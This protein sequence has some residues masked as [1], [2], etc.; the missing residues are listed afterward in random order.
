MTAVMSYCAL[1]LLLVLGKGIRTLIPLLQKLYLP[2][3]I[4]GGILGLVCL[5]AGGG[6]LPTEWS[7]GWA[8]IPGFLINIVF[9][10]LF[11][12]RS[13]PKIGGIRRSVASQLCFGQIMAWGMYVVGLGITALIL[14]PCFHVPPVFG[15]LLEIG[16]EGGHGTVGGL[17][18]TFEELGWDAG[19]ALGYTT[20][21][22]GMVI[23]I[24]VGM[25]LINFAVRRKQVKNIRSFEELT[26]AEQKGFYPVNAQPP[27]GKQ[28]VLCDSIDSLAWHVAVVGLAVLIGYG[29]KQL[30]VVLETALP[31]SVRSLA[32]LRSIPLFPL[33]MLGGL[34]LQWLLSVSHLDN[35]VDFG[36]IQRIGGASL[37]FL[38]VSAVATI[39]L[40]FIVQFWMPLTILLAVGVAWALF[41]ALVLAP[42]MFTDDWFERMICEFGQY[43]GVTATGLLLLRTV[44]PESKTSA[45][46]AF[47]CKQLL[48]EPIMGGG[49]WTSMAVPLVIR[50]GAVP[51]VVISAVAMILWFIFWIFFLRRPAHTEGAH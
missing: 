19:T 6:I 20:A 23:G 18:S 2:S 16:F 28:T 7:T 15:N 35:L 1:C 9:A 33:C 21:T 11:I 10:T 45:P 38:V 50:F 34:L 40:D 14:V 3:S 51:V 32:I 5:N 24:V 47:G 4:I 12:G 17:S 29:M 44:D 13:F 31:E 41:G 46:T 36:Q 42:R 26:D 22:I 43:T 37:D 30:L 25:A 27:A 39:R 49:V 8:A 48:H